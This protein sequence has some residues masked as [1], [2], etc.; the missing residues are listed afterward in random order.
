VYELVKHPSARPNAKLVQI[1]PAREGHVEGCARRCWLISDITSLALLQ[2]QLKAS[3]S[4]KYA[5]VQSK[6]N[7]A[8]TIS[9]ASCQV[10]STP[11]RL[12]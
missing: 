6:A 11:S 4:E 12:C 1:E 2:V 10:Q 9:A 5:E 3:V 7:C 8:S